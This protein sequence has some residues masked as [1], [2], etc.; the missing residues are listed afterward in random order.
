MLQEQEAELRKQ[1]QNEIRDSHGISEALRES[2]NNTVLLLRRTNSRSKGEISVKIPERSDNIND[3]FTI[4]IKYEESYKGRA[5]ILRRDII[6]LKLT[7][8]YIV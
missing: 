2:N 1:L 5:L 6:N 7:L 4:K 8:N 3:F